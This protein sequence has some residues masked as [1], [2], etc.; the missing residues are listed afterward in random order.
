MNSLS[1]SAVGRLPRLRLAPE[2]LGPKAG[3][4][5]REIVNLRSWFEGQFVVHAAQEP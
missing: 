1:V 5:V 2:G 3:N 4:S